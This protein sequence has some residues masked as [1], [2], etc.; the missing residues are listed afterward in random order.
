MFSVMIAGTDCMDQMDEVLSG[1]EE[2][3]KECLVE[4]GFWFEDGGQRMHF[5][6]CYTKEEVE[7]IKEIYSSSLGDMVEISV[8]EMDEDEDLEEDEE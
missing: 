1:L 6:E 8:E 5:F 7:D 3:L 2:D 4:T